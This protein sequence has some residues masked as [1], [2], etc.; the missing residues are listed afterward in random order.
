MYSINVFLTFSLTMFGM[1][2]LWLG[3][4]GQRR[5]IRMLALFVVGFVLCATVLVITVKEKFFFGGWITVVITTLLVCLCFV[6]RRHYDKV[7]KKLAL[8][9]DVFADLPVGSEQHSRAHTL[10]E[11][12]PT[13][14]AVLVS[15]YSGLG[16]HTFLNIFRSFPHQFNH[17][18]FMSVGAISSAEFQSAEHLEEVR[19]RTEANLQR[20]VALAN[21]LGYKAEMRMRLGADVIED[22]SELC[23]EVRKEYNRVT[24]FAGQLVFE[25][26]AWYHRFLHNQTAF[27]IQKKMFWEGSTMVVLPVR[28]RAELKKKRT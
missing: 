25:E 26:E 27:S 18:I 1:I 20:Y 7:S 14:A 3:R 9:D 23:R 21:K 4:K 8:L 11:A 5:Q 12:K 16:I 15:S 17:F 10:N 24:F 22:A 28:V 2:R 6:I 19:R 13:I